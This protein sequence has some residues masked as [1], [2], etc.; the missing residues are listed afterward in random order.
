MKRQREN[1]SPRRRSRRKKRW[2]HTDPR[3]RLWRSLKNRRLGGY[4]FRRRYR[5]GSQT[6]DFYSPDGRLVIE[7]VPEGG[8]SRLPMDGGRSEFMSAHR[9]IWYAL[10]E[11]CITE[12]PETTRSLILALCGWRERL[13]CCPDCAACREARET[14]MVMV[15]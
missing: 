4:K 3:A 9:V 15:F 11:R 12:E 8:E 5:L 7:V 1:R 2:A 10:E 13:A 6:C 14:E